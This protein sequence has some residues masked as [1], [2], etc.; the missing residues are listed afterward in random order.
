MQE[1]ELVLFMVTLFVLLFEGIVVFRP[2]VARTAKDI[3]EILLLEERLAY[4]TEVQRRHQASEYAIQESLDALVTLKYPIQVLALGHYK[5]QDE[6]KRIYLVTTKEYHE[7]QLLHCECELYERT[8]TCSHFIAA[9]SL[10]ASLLKLEQR[11]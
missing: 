3:T 7:E 5:V 4:M 10:H 2:T 8:L 11:V 6:H 9:S 1:T